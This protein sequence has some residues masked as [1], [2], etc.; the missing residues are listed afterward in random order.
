MGQVAAR[1]RSKIAVSGQVA[2]RPYT[3]G[4]LADYVLL[5]SVLP[6]RSRESQ[7]SC[8]GTTFETLD[9]IPKD[10]LRCRRK[11][12]K[13]GQ[14]PCIVMLHCGRIGY[15]DRIRLKIDEHRKS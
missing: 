4:Y 11:P 2:I 13:C 14:G 8:S 10:V 9:P 1:R 12:P 5:E 15:R 7:R 6:P 3:I